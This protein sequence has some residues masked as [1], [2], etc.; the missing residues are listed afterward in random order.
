MNFICYHPQHDP[1]I[2][3]PGNSGSPVEWKL[4]L[5]CIGPKHKEITLQTN[6]ISDS[7]NLTNTFPNDVLFT[8]E[9]FHH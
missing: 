6:V 9:F 3:G 1:S 7:P 2:S 8:D 4:N 5:R